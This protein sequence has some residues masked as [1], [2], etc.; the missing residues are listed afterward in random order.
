MMRD[1]LAVSAIE[2]DVERQ[3]SRFERVIT[4]LRHR[5]N[6]EIVYEIMMYKNHLART[7]QELRLFKDGGTI[8]A[9]Q[10]YEIDEEPALKEWKD[11]WWAKKRN[12]LGCK[13]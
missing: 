13:I 1:T 7:Q 2:A 5:L 10:E 8:V 9:E 12:A 11:Q 4:S 6:P 3:F